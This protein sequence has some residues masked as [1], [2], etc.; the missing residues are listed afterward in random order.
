MTQL[1]HARDK[2]APIDYGCDDIVVVGRIKT[3]GY[4]DMTRQD[5]LL[6]SGR[7]DMQVRIGRVLRGKEP[8][9]IVSVSGYSHGQM[10]EN[11]D[12]WLVLTPAPDGRYTIRTANLARIPYSLAGRCK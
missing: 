3:T 4:T 9:R 5:N 11:S 10:R 12:F 6:G 7:Y 1:V 2:S 8:R